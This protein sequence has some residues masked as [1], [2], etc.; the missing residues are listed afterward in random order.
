MIFNVTKK[1]FFNVAANGFL[2]SQKL[3]FEC[4]KEGV[5]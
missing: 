4:L 1:Q 5:L 2:M 3:D